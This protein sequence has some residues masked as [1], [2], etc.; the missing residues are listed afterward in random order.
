MKCKGCGEEFENMSALLKHK[1]ECPGKTE[2]KPE[3]DCVIPLSL[4]PDELK[5][6]ALNVTV[7]VRVEGKYTPDGIVVQEV[8]FI[9]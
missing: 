3:G 4:C 1:P 8:K 5:Y 9:R 2:P 7:G 6:L